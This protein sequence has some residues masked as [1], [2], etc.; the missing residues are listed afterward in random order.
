MRGNTAVSDRSR[1]AALFPLT[2]DAR[3]VKLQSSGQRQALPRF[4]GATPKT[5]LHKI[6]G[7]TYYYSTLCSFSFTRAINFTYSLPCAFCIVVAFASISSSSSLI[8]F[9]FPHSFGIVCRATFQPA[10]IQFR[11]TLTPI[12]GHFSSSEPLDHAKTHSERV[13]K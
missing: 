8:R 5:G 1:A 4:T 10:T 7:T 6:C 9:T 11:E 12:W 2:V 13:N 3:R